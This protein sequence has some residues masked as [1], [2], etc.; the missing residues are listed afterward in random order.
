[1]NTDKEI[2]ILLVED[3]TNLGFVIKDN[4]DLNGYHVDLCENGELAWQHFNR[5][6]YDLCVLDIMLPKMDG[7]SL[8]EKIRSIND[9]VPILFLS[10]KSMKEDK[11]QGFKIGAD[12]YITKPFSIEELLLRIEVFLRRTSR[13][14][15][16]KES[17]F[18]IGKYKF[19]YK[20]L[21]LEFGKVK[22]SLTKREADLLRQLCLNKDVVLK[23]N[24]ILNKIW[25]DDDYF[26]G[27]SLD[28]FISKLRKYLKDDPSI[29]IVNY[30]AVGFKLEEAN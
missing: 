13:N 30:H 18:E 28:V 6:S 9:Q 10:A 21:C 14:D 27:R 1:M 22:K 5:N 23:R 20:N 26:N 15:L 29:S 12:D 16:D 8:A 4:L 11:I 7:F 3:D 19:D 24:E 17:Q 2:A 25:G